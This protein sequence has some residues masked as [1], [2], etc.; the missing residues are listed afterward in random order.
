VR[1]IR[2]TDL[3]TDG[4]RLSSVSDQHEKLHIALLEEREKG[5]ASDYYKGN[6]NAKF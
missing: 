3:H 2:N 1:S 5:T 6:T 4:G